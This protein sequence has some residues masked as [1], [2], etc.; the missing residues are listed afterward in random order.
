MW[1]EEVRG[2][3]RVEEVRGMYSGFFRVKRER[4]ECHGRESAVEIR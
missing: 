4:G 1:V 3:L 2:N